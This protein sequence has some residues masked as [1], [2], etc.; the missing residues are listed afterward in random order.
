[1][2]VKDKLIVLQRGYG[3]E[4]SEAR[5]SA[6]ADF[7]LLLVVNGRLGT[8]W[9]ISGPEEIRA[10]LPEMLRALANDIEEMGRVQ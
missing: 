6:K 5:E 2:T 3:L 8:G 7:C 4:C 1:M 9:G 10:K